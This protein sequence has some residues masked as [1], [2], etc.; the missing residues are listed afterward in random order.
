MKA[1]LLKGKLD[2]SV[3]EVPLP[4]IGDDEILLKV[5]AASIYGSDVRM[6]KNGYQHVSKEH[7]SLIHISEPTRH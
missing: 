3:E 1:A 4:E 2:I 7:L 6:Y 5:K